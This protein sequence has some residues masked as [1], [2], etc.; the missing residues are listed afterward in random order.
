MLD[1]YGEQI[2]SRVIGTYVPLA[3]CGRDI[4]VSYT[5]LSDTA[6]IPRR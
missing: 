3:F 1:R 5:H 6:R 2:N 4:P